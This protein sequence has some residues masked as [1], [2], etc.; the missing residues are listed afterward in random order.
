VITSPSDNGVESQ[1]RAEAVNDA[2]RRSSSVRL[3]D[4]I[5]STSPTMIERILTISWDAH[6]SATY[7]PSYISGCSR[8]LQWRRQRH[9]PQQRSWFWVI[10][11]VNGGYTLWLRVSSVH[12]FPSEYVPSATILHHNRTI[13]ATPFYCSICP[14]P[15][16]PH[17]QVSQFTLLEFVRLNPPA[18]PYAT[19]FCVCDW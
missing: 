13:L 10:N 2:V 17:L 19:A 16:V 18:A 15:P 14:E 11:N 7:G 5:R 4:G 8:P 1:R 3:R 9:E 6:A 12:H